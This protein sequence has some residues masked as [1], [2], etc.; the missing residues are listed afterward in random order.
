MSAPHPFDPTYD[1]KVTLQEAS[2]MVA[3]HVASPLAPGELKAAMFGSLAFT[4]ILGQPGCQ[5]IRIY[6]AR[7]SSGQPTLVMV[8]VDAQGVDLPGDQV[9]CSENTDPCPPN[10]G[11][12]SLP[13]H[14]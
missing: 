9:E 4:R 5:G 10:C 12:V 2:D 14:P 13:L 7:E 6:L 1:H 11:G 8:G 3:A